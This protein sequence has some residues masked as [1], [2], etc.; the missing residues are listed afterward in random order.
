MDAQRAWCFYAYAQ[1]MERRASGDRLANLLGAIAAYREA[2][3]AIQKASLLEWAALQQQCGLALFAAWRIV[4][5]RLRDRG[6]EGGETGVEQG[7]AGMERQALWEE[8]KTRL[9]AAVG[10]L[11]LEGCGEEEA[12]R[13]NDVDPAE[14]S[15][16][17]M[18]SSSGSSSD[19]SASILFSFQPR[20]TTLTLPR[21]A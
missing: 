7:R 15:S 12:G 6:S 10:V 4:C 1:I 13:G 19:Q 20:R 11:G 5:K 17:G 14:A 16:K 18:E 21:R 2:E 3:G 9:E 8:A